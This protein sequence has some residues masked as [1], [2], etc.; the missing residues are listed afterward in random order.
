MTKQL[1]KYIL[2]VKVILFFCN[3]Y[4]SA[5][6]VR[7]VDYDT[8]GTYKYTVP[9]GITE[10]VVECWGAGG[11]GSAAIGIRQNNAA[12]GAGGGGGAHAHSVIRVTPGSIFHLTVGAGGAGGTSPYTLSEGHGQNGGNTYI[13]DSNNELLV[14]AEGGKG[15]SFA[16]LSQGGSLGGN[17]GRYAASI[18]TVIHTGGK[19]GNAGSSYSGAGGGAGGRTHEGYNATGLN[20][21]SAGSCYCGIPGAGGMGLNTTGSG[22]AAPNYENKG[23][24][25]IYAGGG[26]A[27]GFDSGW[28][29]QIGGKGANGHIRIKEQQILGDIIGQTYL[30]VGKT[31]QLIPPLSGGRW[32][33]SLVN[34]ASVDETGLVTGL[35][36]GEVVISYIMGG[37]VNDQSTEIT[38]NVYPEG[39]SIA[40]MGL[41]SYCANG[42]SYINLEASSNTKSNVNWFWTGP[43]NFTYGG[44]GFIRNAV[45][46]NSGIYKVTA[47][48]LAE[49]SNTINLI[50]NGDFE[51][52]NINFTSDFQYN[53]YNQSSGEYNISSKPI[54]WAFSEGSCGDKTSGSGNFMSLIGNGS[55]KNI[56]GQTVAVEPNTNYQFSFWGQAIQ[57]SDWNYTAN[58]NIQPKINGENISNTF[59]LTSSKICT[60]WYQYTYNWNSG[61]NTSAD[62]DL[63]LSEDLDNHYLLGLD[64]IS[65]KALS[66]IIISAEV[67]IS[68]G[69]SFTPNI[70]ILAFP[71]TVTEGRVNTFIASSEH[72]G[73]DPTYVWYVNGIEVASGR[74]SVHSA[75]NLRVGDHVTCELIPDKIECVSVDGP[76]F[77]NTIEMQSDDKNYWSGLVS[78]K[79]YV[80]DNWTKVKVPSSGDDIEFAT[81]EKAGIAVQGDLEITEHIVVRNYINESDKKI[82]ITPGASLTI[83]G[84]IDTASENK[85]LIQAAENRPN[86][87]LI[88]K[89]ISQTPMATIE[90]WS[91]GQI[92]SDN[93]KKNQIKWQYFGIPVQS[94]T[95]SPTFAGAY[96]RKYVEEKPTS[97][98]GQQWDQLTNTSIMKPFVGYQISQPEPAKYSITGQLVKQ[99]FITNLSRTPD[100]YYGGQHIL[101]NPYTAA[102][103]ITRINFGDGLEKTIHLYNTGSYYDWANATSIPTETSTPGSYTSIPQQQAQAM[104]LDEIPSMQGFLVRVMDE[105]KDCSFGFKYNDV[106]KLNT[107]SLKSVKEKSFLAVTLSGKQH[108][109]K[110]WLFEESDCS[111]YYDNGWD[112]YKIFAPSAA[113]IFFTEQNFNYQVCSTNNIDGVYLGIYANENDSVY[114]IY[115]DNNNLES[116]YSEL[117][118]ID[119]KTSAK[120]NI[121]NKNAKYS[122]R[123]I[124]NEKITDRFLI[125]S[126]P[127]IHTETDKILSL[128][129]NNKTLYINNASSESGYF[130]IYNLY[131]H[132][133]IKDRAFDANSMTTIPLN[134]SAGVYI[135]KARINANEET[136]KVVIH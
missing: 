3:S 53:Q 44:A 94:L 20:A 93:N 18:G 38:L 2:I 45:I 108:S 29:T 64:E 51:S 17:G 131:G 118:L 27:G 95:A 88:F 41:R 100:S 104:G 126:D 15:A 56:W 96:V 21:G 128:Y 22:T 113:Q 48:R 116:Q 32:R 14:V 34:I 114:T 70:K 57:K 63:I 6:A 11:G 117:Y 65:L 33:S 35:Q 28:G 97:T 120:I 30:E 110:A 115:F 46:E 89:N 67:N 16:W 98:I 91:K 42:S 36:P 103:D 136:A 59:V 39:E 134:L 125:T 77:S 85:I 101:S 19:G 84:E 112:A 111:P 79:W 102:I 80:A 73:I 124:A 123:A 58:I 52:G 69:T 130:T 87:S 12:P 83:N 81:K 24:G 133:L 78:N 72:E 106:V 23:R 132:S 99:D 55:S 7:I 60:G 74:E 47:S 61:N 86:G 109:D 135:V 9:S 92:L 43:N 68:V 49:S 62:I 37:S 122:F 71:N 5:Q 40:I 90:I 8:P 119:L 82:I 75:I 54:E 50:K 4:L 76:Y 26:G 107:T 105:N 25:V 121:L 31:T 129:V 13:S 127:N 66:P 10:I 1:L